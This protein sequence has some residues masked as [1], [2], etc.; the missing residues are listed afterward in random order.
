MSYLDI[1]FVLQKVDNGVRGSE[2]QDFKDKRRN[3]HELN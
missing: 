1:D 2:L 3:V